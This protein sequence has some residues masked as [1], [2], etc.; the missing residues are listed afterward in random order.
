[1]P[2]F[3]AGAWAYTSQLGHNETLNRSWKFYLSCIISASLMTVSLTIRADMIFF[4]PLLIA[5]V[6]FRNK[7]AVLPLVAIIASSCILFLI[8][9]HLAVGGE[10]PSAIDYFARF[11]RFERV[12][13]N[14]M[15]AIYP[16]SG[17]LLL[18]TAI[19]LLK[20]KN[21]F[22][23]P[24]Y[25]LAGLIALTPNLLFWL[26]V[27][28]C[29]RHFA[30]L[31]ITVSV[32]YA[33]LLAKG[34]NL[35]TLSSVSIAVILSLFSNMLITE[36]GFRILSPM[37]PP[38]TVQLGVQRRVMESV[39]LGIPWL[40]HAAQQQMN[41]L[42]EQYCINALS[43]ANTRP[44]IFVQSSPYRLCVL[45]LHRYGKVRRLK[46]SNGLTFWQLGASE[47]SPWCVD[48][49]ESADVEW[50]KSLQSFAKR[51]NRELVFLGPRIP[52]ALI[53]VLNEQSE[54]EVQSAEKERMRLLSLQ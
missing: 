13:I 54:G 30:P 8:L 7:K 27:G 28:P 49:P 6:Y 41:E 43:H 44:V 14:L 32:L 5:L 47:N 16:I 22:F 12:P 2:F 15:L 42:Q 24:N 3:A 51:H 33:Y 45:A 20:L 21:E 48:I 19:Y 40:N 10:R 17:Y 18:I 35:T 50:L 31:Y 23:N 9:R 29:L 34:L 38:R 4:M 36:L 1:M 26:P 37:F 53:G 46:D 25:L 39:T 52:K 11:A